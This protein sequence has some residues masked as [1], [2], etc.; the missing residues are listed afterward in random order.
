MAVPPRAQ[1]QPQPQPLPYAPSGYPPGAPGLSALTPVGPY[2]LLNDEPLGSRDGDLLGARRAAVRLAALLRGSHRSTPFTL[3]IDAGWGMGKSSLMRLVDAEL[4]APGGPGAPA[5]HT[6]WYNA[7]TSTGGDALEGLI[8]SV[9]GSMDRNVLRRAVRRA[10]EHP[11][12][13]RAVRAL[14][15]LLGRPLGLSGTIDELWTAMSA[16]PQAR[17]H[18]REALRT[19]VADWSGGDGPDRPGRM[20]VV[21]IDDLDRCTEATVLAVCEAVKVYLDVP[22]LAF[23]VGADQNAIGPAGLLRDLSPAGAAFM[24]KIFQTSYRV[25]VGSP[26]DIRGYVLRCAE[27]AGIA[28]L[29]DHDLA[30]LVAQRSARNP[31]RIKRLINFFLLEALL[32]PLWDQVAPETVIRTLLLQYLY[33]GFYRMMTLPPAGP[34]GQD[35]V[36]EF[37]DYRQVRT[38]L[39]AMP[40]GAGPVD[41]TAQ[42]QVRTF[43]TRQGLPPHDSFDRPT[44]TLAELEQQLPTDFPALVADPSFTSLLDELLAATGAPDVLRRLR[45]G[46]STPAAG[47]VDTSPPPLGDPVPGQTDPGSAYPPYPGPSFPGYPEPPSRQG[48]YPVQVGYPEPAGYDPGPDYGFP[49]QGGGVYGAQGGVP[50]QAYPVVRTPVVALADGNTLTEMFGAMTR[51]YTIYPATSEAEAVRGLGSGQAL[52]ICDVDLGDG[53]DRGF[54]FVTEL[55]DS[56]TWTGPVVFFTHRLTPRREARAAELGAEITNDV[57]ALPG[58]ATRALAAVPQQTPRPAAAAPQAAP[59]EEH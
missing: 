22:G 5:V 45:E 3:A 58:L 56:G 35:V 47:R 8:K 31:R 29:F 55:R 9:L 48:P 52:L 59:R 6:V 44:E 20:L 26:A 28:A 14:T 38:V 33:P 43:L 42:E 11:A 7:W 46:T 50:Q 32:T 39:R 54:D 51:L 15:V 13:V 16:D 49:Q 27:D 12:L 30:D 24:E 17:N 18:M 19:I 21:F 25:P 2:A 40:G 41:R 53:T 10:S 1:P 37:T 23:V 36:A 4:R 34:A 57:R